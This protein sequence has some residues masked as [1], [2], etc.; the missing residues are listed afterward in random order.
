MPS[1]RT[2]L[3]EGLPGPR[4]GAPVGS[5]VRVDVGTSP[6]RSGRKRLVAGAVA[7]AAVLA[8]T[9]VVWADPLAGDSVITGCVAPKGALRIVEGAE[10]CRDSE[11]ALTWNERG[12]KGDPGVPGPK[13]EPG[14]PGADGLPGADGAPGPQGEPGAPGVKGDTGEP[15]AT[16]AMGPQGPAGPSSRVVT[17]SASFRGGIIPV[18]VNSAE[19]GTMVTLQP[20]AGTWM[21]DGKVA[22]ANHASSPLQ[23]ACEVWLNDTS[24]VDAVVH[25]LDVHPGPYQT[26][27]IFSA[28]QVLTATDVLAIK[29]GAGSSQATAEVRAYNIRL[30]AREAA[31]VSGS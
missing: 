4:K 24:T 3:L 13:G 31:S 15:G 7:A 19:R 10:E 5:E 6:R 21:I 29:C 14:A 20:G 22:L 1:V 25:Q 28:P 26:Q 30:T 17:N 11:T 23:V 27:M 16:G 12:P 2:V 18:P 8:G 9:G